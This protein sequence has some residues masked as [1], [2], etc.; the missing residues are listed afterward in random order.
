MVNFEAPQSLEIYLHRVGRTAR[1]GRSGKSCTLV[2][3][4]DRKVVKGAVK[5]GRKHGAKIKA[6]TVDTETV[7]TWDQKV[8]GLEQQVEDILKEE[9]E[10]RVMDNTEREL[11]RADNLVKHKEEIFGRPRKTWF[12][13]T[14]DKD[15]AKQKGA[16]A[17][18]GEAGRDK[19]VNGKKGKMSNKQKKRLMDR[20]ERKEGMWK[21]GKTTEATDALKKGYEKNKKAKSSKP[22]RKGKR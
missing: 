17:L 20:D 1:A 11:A 8:Q 22:M 13:S 12:E 15:K 2:A 7:E 18:N 16:E 10:Q 6:R 9:K 14:A 4:G 19:K 3:E 21:K 5:T